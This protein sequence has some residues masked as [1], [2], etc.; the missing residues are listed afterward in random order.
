[1]DCLGRE[2]FKQQEPKDTTAPLSSGCLGPGMN[3]LVM[4]LLSVQVLA[5]SS[6]ASTNLPFSNL[7][8][9]VAG[10][11]Y[12]GFAFAVCV[13]KKV[14]HCKRCRMQTLPCK[15]QNI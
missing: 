12:F 3:C 14:G 11:W 9:P 10:L 13:I 6:L 5:Y 4:Y 2:F 7:P 1:M 15:G 8:L